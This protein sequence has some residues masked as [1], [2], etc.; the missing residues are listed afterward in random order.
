M[1][2]TSVIFKKPYTVVLQEEPL[3]ALKAKEVLVKTQFSAISPGSEMLV[4]RGQFPSNLSVDAKIQALSKPFHYPLKYGY[5]L[6]GNVIAVGSAVKPNWLDR[7]VFCFHP[8]NS[9][10]VVRSSEL[11]PI[12]ED[13][14]ATEALFLPNMETAVNFLMDG[15][16]TIGERVVVFGQ[17]IVGLLT[18]A[19]L[20]QYPL[21]RLVTLDRFPARR[22]KSLDVGSEVAL[23]P[24][25]D[26]IESDLTRLLKLDSSEGAADLVFEL[27]GNPQ[28]L[29]QA[30]A[31]AGFG[32]RVIIGSWY[33]TKSA[34]LEL[35]GKFHRNRIR[36]I[37]S[38]VST[39]SPEFTHQWT[40]QRRL[41]TV[42]DMIRKTKPTQFI[43][44][45]YH[46]SQIK[47]AFEVLD[48]KP[49]RVIQIII[50]YDG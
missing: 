8:H 40:K 41:E 14:N 42:W 31:I 29:N 44:H 1:K 48:K 32:A 17:G 46:I 24:Q 34:N 25:C 10:C 49:E 36:L 21:S 23:D 20:A 33:G 3:P 4:Y 15:R 35:G 37:S 22:R 47:K 39:I 12:P 43:T 7:P 27:S 38:Q 30:I 26:T 16:P 13:I 45:R 50:S 9:H 11:I 19:L 2:Q 5:S 6:V 28:A 18:T